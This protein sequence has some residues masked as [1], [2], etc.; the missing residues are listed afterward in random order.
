MSPGPEAIAGPVPG[1]PVG[2]MVPYDDLV[3]D[4]SLLMPFNWQG[5]ISTY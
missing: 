3:V 2:L 4:A 5:K 1:H